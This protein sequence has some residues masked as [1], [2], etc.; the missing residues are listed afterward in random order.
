MVLLY[1]RILAIKTSE[2][3]SLVVRWMNLKSV[4]QSEVKKE[5]KENRYS[6]LMCIYVKP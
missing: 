4:T 3:K 6:I 2:F 1:N 5:N